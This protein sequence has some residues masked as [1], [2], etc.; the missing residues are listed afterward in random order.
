MPALP[1]PGKVIRCDLFF[2]YGPNTRVRDRIFF[3]Y[4]GAGPNATDLTTLAGTIS[5]AWN[6]NMVPQV[7]PGM[8]LTGITLTDL[9]SNV[10]SQVAT[11]Q[12]RPGTL[13]GVA[14]P[15]GTAMVIKFKVNRRY[16]GGHPRFY[17]AGRVSADLFQ[18]NQWVPA[19]ATAV[20]TGFAA[21][22]AACEVTPPTNIGTMGHVNVSYFA[23]FT[24]T[25]FPTGR[26]RNIPKVRPT[27]AVDAITNYSVN[28][29]VASQRRRNSQSA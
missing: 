19:S 29:L 3:S 12:N 13:A 6:T 15:D 25:V 28:G 18:L 1:S 5:A 21:F 2:T 9:A 24:A 4:A 7:S 20:A 8:I 27:P 17:L 23:G 26:Y 14:L 11:T 10:G 16:R 22:I